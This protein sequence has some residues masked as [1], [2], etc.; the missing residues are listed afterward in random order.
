[1]I[2]VLNFIGTLLTLAVMCVVMVVLLA[3][4]VPVYVVQQA[5]RVVMVSCEA[6]LMGSFHADMLWQLTRTEFV[7]RMLRGD[8]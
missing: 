6:I 3:V 2:G 1:M 4:I 8:R 5:C 7:G